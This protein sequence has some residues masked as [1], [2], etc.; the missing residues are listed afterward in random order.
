MCVDY[1]VVCIEYWVVVGYELG[2]EDCCV[3]G[4]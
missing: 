1:L 3:V 4:E 2:V